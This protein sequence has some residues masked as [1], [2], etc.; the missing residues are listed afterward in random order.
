MKWD[1]ERIL[2]GC[3]DQETCDSEGIPRIAESASPGKLVEMEIHGNHNRCTDS[4]FLGGG[5]GAVRK[6]VT[7]RLE[8]AFLIISYSTY[9]LISEHCVN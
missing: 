1:W 6:S 4:E 2:L 9:N 8:S 3:N 5:R 7:Q